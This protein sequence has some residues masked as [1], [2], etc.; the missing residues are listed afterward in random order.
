PLQ[1][2]SPSASPSPKSPE[3]PEDSTLASLVETCDALDD[4]LDGDVDQGGVC[5]RACGADAVALAAQTLRLPRAGDPTVAPDAGIAPQLLA[6]GTIPA[7]CT[8]P[9]MS[10]DPDEMTV[11]C[12]ETVTFPGGGIL[13]KAIRIAPGGVLRLTDETILSATDILV[14]PG[15]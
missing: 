7:F 11:G 8:A 5:R 12:G 1:P 15:A 4:D 14:C 10:S 9:T 13:K 6:Y 3:S 2:A